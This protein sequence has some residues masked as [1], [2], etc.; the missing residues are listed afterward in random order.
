MCCGQAMEELV[1]N[2]TDAAVEKHVPVYK[3]EGNKVFV[4]ISDVLHPMEEKH[5]IQWIGIE[6]N[7]G[8]QIKHLTPG[9]EPK[10]CFALCDSEKVETV[11]EYCNLHGLWKA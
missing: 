2:T 10:A 4:T 3:T 8:I 6:T 7:L 1:P 11:F 9:M 5:F